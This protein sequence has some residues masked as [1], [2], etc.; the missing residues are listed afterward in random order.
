M[1]SLSS[2]FPPYTGSH[3]VGTVDIEVPVREPRTIGDVVFKE[4]GEPAFQVYPFFSR[5]ELVWLMMRN[6]A[7][8]RPLFALLPRPALCTL[9]VPQAPL[10]STATNTYGSRLRPLRGARRR[11]RGASVW[12][13]TMGDCRGGADQRRS[14]RCTARCA[15]CRR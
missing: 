6:I 1:P 4:G 15:R 9:A 5:S 7:R 10:D 11:R 3:G 13:R 14:G 12:C 8:H 2:K